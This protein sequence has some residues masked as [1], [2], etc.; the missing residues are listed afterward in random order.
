MGNLPDT[1]VLWTRSGEPSR[2]SGALDQE[3]GTFKAQRCSGLGV[4][5]LQGTAVLWTR[6]GEP[7]R[8]SGALDQEWGTFQTQRC[9]GPGVGNLQGITG[10]IARIFSAGRIYIS[11]VKSK[12]SSSKNLVESQKKGHHV[13]RS[14]IFRPKSSEEQQNGHH[15]R[16]P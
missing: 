13:R 1:A 11:C 3:W 15:V 6:S 4:G 14:L 8:H 7:S 10:H 2:Y 9:S 16:R 12:K 5:N